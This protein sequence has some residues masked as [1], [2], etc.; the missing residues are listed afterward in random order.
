VS[1]TALAAACV[2]ESERGE[3]ERGERGS[4]RERERDREGRES[5]E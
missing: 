2:R 4:D 3:R 1:A 5:R